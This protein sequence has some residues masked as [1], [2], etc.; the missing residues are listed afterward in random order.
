MLLTMGSLCQ[1]ALEPVEGDSR[2]GVATSQHSLGLVQRLTLFALL[3]AAEWIPVSYLVHKH[4]G[5]GTLLQFTVVFASVFLA[6]GYASAKSTFLRVSNELKEV[7]IAWG[8]FGAHLF[9]F[10]VFVW[11]SRLQFGAE[12]H[13]LPAYSLSAAWFLSGVLAVAFA[14]LALMPATL[15]FQLVRSSGQASAYGLVVGV[16][17]WRLAGVVSLWNGS[18]WKPTTDLTFSLVRIFLNLFLPVVVADRATMIIGGQNFQVAI[19]P[20]CSGFE[21]T[22]LMLVFSI[23]WLWFV[24]RELRFPQA[25]LLIPAAMVIIWIS[26]AL[27][28]TALILIGVAGAPEVALGGFHSQAGWIA[29]NAV[30]LSFSVAATRLPWVAAKH[31]TPCD[32]ASTT[33]PVAAYLLPFLMILGAAMI[34]RAVAGGME[35]LY[36]LRFFAAAGALWVF[37]DKYTALE[38]KFGWAAPLTGCVVFVIWIG[39][40][41]VFGTQSNNSIG[42]ALASAPAAARIAWLAFRTV[43]A[44]VTVP[45][46]EELAFRGFLLRRMFSSNFE[47][48][49][50][51]QFSFFAFVVSSVAFGVMHGDRWFAGTVAGLLYAGVLMWRGRIGDAVVAHATTNALI[52]AWVLFSG[53]WDLW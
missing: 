41:R 17:A 5:A 53:S 42:T 52:A 26:N 29:F 16:I 11:L 34:S 4:T 24:R 13:S 48:V 45:M 14:G 44:V 36:P 3:F 7:P 25:L 12:Q 18:F 46:A 2:H 21:G 10:L 19:L 51:Q 6:F 32:G 50:F 39:L 47:S 8:F 43:G 28:I 22:A 23:A 49:S 35:W 20:W 27:R 30:A 31:H 15:I 40:D 38:W 1:P 37:R 33:N 9:A